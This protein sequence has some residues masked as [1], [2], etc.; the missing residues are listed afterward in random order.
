MVIFDAQPA[1]NLL[2]SALPDSDQHRWRH[3]L[4]PVDLQLG[5]VL[6]E[7]GRTPSHVYFP[8]TAIVS[9]LHVL[10]DGSS[11]EVAMVGCEGVVG[12]SSFLGGVTTPSRS[13]VRSAGQGFRLAAGL[14]QEE[15]EQHA[16]V[17]QL[18]LK[19]TQALMCQMLQN[20]VCNRHHSVEQH[21]CRCLLESLDRLG[22]NEL[23]MTHELIAQM[24]GVRR[25]GVTEAALKLQAAGLIRYHSGHITVLDRRGLEHRSC[26]CHAVVKREYARLLPDLRMASNSFSP[27]DGALIPD[28]R[29]VHS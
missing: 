24:L 13:V 11:T 12:I 28:L 23:V 20:A 10:Q 3:L 15:F 5:Q 29:L 22:G 4:E 6:S 21:I 1:E 18:M 17:K 26:E 19:Y 2:V 7:S 27:R 9:I 25:S 14:I 16:T 8:T